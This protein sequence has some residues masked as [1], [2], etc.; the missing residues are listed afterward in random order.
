MDPWIRARH[1]RLAQRMAQQELPDLLE[2]AGRR[3]L[4]AVEVE[5]GL[6]ARLG[7][8]MHGYDTDDGSDPIRFGY[9][10]PDR[11]LGALTAA[12]IEAVGPPDEVPQAADFEP[13]G[14]LFGAWRLWEVLREISPAAETGPLYEFEKGLRSRFRALMP[15]STVRTLVADSLC[16]ACDAYGSRFLIAAEFERVGRKRWYAWDVDACGYE[17][18]TVNAGFHESS[19]S[20]L[21][22]WR[23]AVGETAAA[24]AVLKPVGDA[25]RW[26][27]IAALLPEIESFGRMGGESAAQLGEYHRSRRLAFA[28]REARSFADRVPGADSGPEEQTRERADQF[29][30]WLSEREPGRVYAFDIEELALELADTWAGVLPQEL[31]LTCS[32]HRVAAKLQFMHGYFREEFTAPLQELLPHWVRWIAEQ[33]GLAGHLLER[34]LEY[35]DGRSHPAQTRDGRELEWYAVCVE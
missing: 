15:E 17:A 35:C 16:W 34:S 24:A 20:A 21:E 9:L 10:D 4:D 12:A 5:D 13:D 26:G 1:D 18:V 22:S 31:F 25:A 6:C 23:A 8:L 2:F 33:T 27:L 29:A 19:A 32:P 30:S 28:V 3:E 14:G 11:V 7:D